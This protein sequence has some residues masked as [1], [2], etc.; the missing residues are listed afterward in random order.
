MEGKAVEAQLLCDV[1]HVSLQV[2]DNGYELL[3]GCSFTTTFQIVHKKHSHDP[4][5]TETYKNRN[6]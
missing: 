5:K 4:T 6:S 3:N 2:S 1:H